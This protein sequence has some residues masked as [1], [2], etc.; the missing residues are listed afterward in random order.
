MI[1]L[2]AIIG[3]LILWICDMSMTLYNVKKGLKV[4]P[5]LELSKVEGNL[6][7]VFFWKKFGINKG[8]LIAMICQI[9]IFGILI[10]CFSKFPQMAYF[11]LG[12]YFIIFYMHYLN[13][14]DLRKVK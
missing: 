13:F 1:S 11:M 14:M 6:M 5:F 12:A 10:W 9:P 3:I 8:T 2:Y 7:V 4:N